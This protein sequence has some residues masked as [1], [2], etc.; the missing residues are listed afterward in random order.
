MT[1][2]SSKSL[3]SVTCRLLWSSTALISLACSSIRPND[4]CPS[5][6]VC[7]ETFGPGYLCNDQGLCEP[8]AAEA[9]C[10]DQYP[11]GLLQN[12]EKYK[13][14]VVF[15]SLLADSGKEGARQDAIILAIDSANRSLA[16]LEANYPEIDG[17]RFG[18]VQCDHDGDRAEIARL[19]EYLVEKVGSPLL[20]GPAS[21]AASLATHELI[22][23]DENGNPESDAVIISP[24]AT[25]VALTSADTL[26]PGMLWRTAYMDDA[27]VYAM[28]AYADATEKPYAVFY[29]DTAYGQG[30][31]DGLK[32][33]S[34]I[35]CVDCG[36]SFDAKTDNLEA[37][38]RALVSIEGERALEAAE[39]VF[40]MGGQEGQI[41]AMMDQMLSLDSLRG[42]EVFFSDGAASG[43]SANDASPGNFDRILGSRIAAPPDTT[44]YRLFS[45]A[46]SAAYDTEPAL[47]SF[48]ANAYDSA[49]L[50]II[51]ALENRL[52]NVPVRAQHLADALRHMSSSSWASIAEQECPG[53]FSAG[54]C[55]AITLSALEME[56][57]I[58]GLKEFGEVNI[59][60]ASSALDYCK[61]DEELY[62]VNNAFELWRLEEREAN[63][64]ISAGYD[65]APLSEQKVFIPQ[66]SCP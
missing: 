28:K 16:D 52:R 59:T 27:Q 29:E 42:K 58:L 64:D 46:F 34:Q 61:S 15:G 45:A 21:S 30:L 31:F 35:P 47:H 60:G 50:G 37:V 63:G 54:E 3:V 33:I 55:Q 20:L 56:K 18:L 22:N 6:E 48:T 1:I 38:I 62:R 39:L 11:D 12:P 49:W 23:F 24:S 4:D 25:S 2:F 7:R 43:D 9:T 8:A 53:E 40:F 51:A 44:A 17:L 10:H 14:Y 65:I 5:N 32:E 19:G 41:E 13:D 66:E 36:V 57:I 26:Q